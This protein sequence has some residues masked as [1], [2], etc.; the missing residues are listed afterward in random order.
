MHDEKEMDHVLGIEGVE[1][2][3]INNRNLGKIFQGLLIS[4]CVNYHVAITYEC[5]VIT[6]LFI[7]IV[8]GNS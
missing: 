6:S 2:I 5:L 8:D 1:F 3:G 4:L 7:N